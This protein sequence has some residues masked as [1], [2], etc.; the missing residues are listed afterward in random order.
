MFQRFP[1][2]LELVMPASKSAELS[3]LASFSF[4][5]LNRDHAD[6]IS[7]GH[8]LI[9]STGGEEKHRKSPRPDKMGFE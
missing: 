2:T 6:N 4:D 1:G 7:Q 9:E 5:R 8:S 3:V